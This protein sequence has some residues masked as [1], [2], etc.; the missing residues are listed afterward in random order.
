MAKH[1][2]RPLDPNQLGKLIVALSVG[3]ASDPT[4]V[5][6]TPA[7]TRQFSAWFK[8]ID[9]ELQF[10]NR[11]L[12]TGGGEW[13]D[14]F[15]RRL[16]PDLPVEDWIVN[17]MVIDDSRPLKVLDVGAGP[18]T[19]FGRR[20]KGVKIDITAVDPLAPFYAE[21]ANRLS[22]ERPTDT[23]QAFA[24]DL[25]AYF[26]VS[27]FDLVHCRNALDHSFDPMR[28]IEEML[29]VTRVGGRVLLIHN[30][31]EGETEGYLGFHQWNFDVENDHFI[32]WS[33]QSRIDVTK[34]V[35]SYAEVTARCYESGRS[36][37]LSMTK[38]NEVPFD[39]SRSRE[40]VRDIYSAVLF[41]L[42][43]GTQTAR[44]VSG[45]EST[46]QTETLVRQEAGEIQPVNVRPR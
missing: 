14:D 28:G 17:G 4:P 39:L 27:S 11:F 25:T 44:K 35:E 38:H 29:A 45:A 10:W 2:K 6:D 16:D 19:T 37:L 8:G 31:N 46:F 41:C 43:N 12:E 40:R 5:P 34:S 36:C 30:T 33:K 3:E 1:P 23:V 20:H 24:E 18:L 15:K 32:I 9:Y 42:V 22:I 7:L 26:E 21:I 13:P